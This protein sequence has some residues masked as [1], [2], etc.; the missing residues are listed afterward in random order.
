M[1]LPSADAFTG[2]A[3]I[4]VLCAIAG[5]AASLLRQPLIIGFI[6]VGVLVGPSGLGLV[7]NPEQM[8]VL[9]EIGLALL[10]FV[11]GLRLDLHLIKS[12]GRVALTTALGQGLI[13]TAGG[14]AIAIGLGMAPVTALY[15]AVCL[16][17]SSTIIIVK[18][19]SDK[20]ETES[21]HG[22]IALGFLIVQD[23]VVVLVMIALSAITGGSAQHAFIVALLVIVKGL[24]LLAATAIISLLV[25]PRILHLLAKSAELL[26]VFAITWALAMAAV[27]EAMGFS[28]EV[29]AFLAGVALASTQFREIIGAKLVG[30]RDFTLLFFFIQLGSQLDVADTGSQVYAAMPLCMFVLIVKPIIL[31]AILGIMGYRK[32]TSFLT[33]LSSAQISEFSLILV[34]MGAKLGQIDSGAVGLVTLIGLVTFALS[35]YMIIFSNQIYR[36]LSPY[37]GFLQLRSARREQESDAPADE[38]R[39][40]E[41]IIFGLGRYGR[42]IALELLARGRRVL[43]VDFDPQVIRNWKHD[44]LPAVFGDPEDAEFLLSLPL[45]TTKWVVSAIRDV[46]TNRALKRSLDYVGYKGFTAFAASE[47]ED[48][49]RLA[50]AGTD[51]VLT[52]LEDAAAEAVD[53]ITSKEAEVARRNMDKLIDSMSGHYIICGFGRMGQQ[54]A[55]D[56]QAAGKQFVVIETNPEQLPKLIEGNIPH[57]IGTASEDATLLKAGIDRAKGL[58]SVLPTDED[59]VFVVLTARVLN[60]N[61]F[62]VARSILEA[63]EDK[64]RRAGAD[65]VMSPYTLGGR[66]MALAVIKPEVMDFLDLVLHSEQFD[67]N[68]G[69]VILPTTSP[70]VGKSISELGLWQNCGVTVL[71]VTR[72]EKLLANP[73]PTFELEPDDELIFMGG[74]AE[75][76]AAREYLTHGVPMVGK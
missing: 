48:S 15:V 52:P 6:G 29:G 46:N 25:F 16:T 13:A 65:K 58:I 19:L 76:D 69:H 66:R 18:L 10:L 75:L 62:I 72:A 32:R 7:R 45:G 27:A 55:K 20:R 54:I 41:I 35:S 23:L 8:H 22:R 57:V 50:K 5:V 12:M 40:P 68:I 51:I 11:V 71:A 44:R 30:V 47:L 53:V 33:G 14:Y 42:T 43:G 61:L 49:D 28:K 4:L 31:M 59:N 26:M 1:H 73:C 36:R 39:R 3:V 21:L 56:F 34:A 38:I 74:Q 24:A 60:P 37:V 64:L 67:T 9:A 17:F 2:M 63:N 70:L